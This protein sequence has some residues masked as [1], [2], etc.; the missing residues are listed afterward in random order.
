MKSK[1]QKILEYIKSLP[2]GNKI[3]VRQVAKDLKV[4][5]GTAY[6]AIKES[7][8]RGFV[9]SIERVGTV[10]IQKKERD[11]I[12]K[13]SY[14]EIVNIV[15]GQ[16]IA[17]RG[18]IH[19]IVQDFAIGAMDEEQVSQHIR[20]GTLLI[21]GNR[22]NI[23]S[24]ALEKDCAI[25]VAG[26][27]VPSEDIRKIADKKN[28]PLIVTPHDS[29]SVAHLINRVTNDQ[30]IKR[31]IVTVESIY[32]PKES[33]YTINIMS[34][35]QDWY[36]LQLEVGHTRFPV[37]NEYGKL[38]GIV[39]ARDVFSKHKDISIRD[40]MERKVTTA[41]LNDPVSSVGN[42]MLSEG[43]EL[44]PVID[45]KNTLLGIVTRKIVINSMLTNN[46]YQENQN[47]DTFDEII[48]KG[49]VPRADGLQIKVIPQ[50]LDQF[51]TFSRSALLSI[52]DESIHIT[53]YNY[54]RSEVLMQNVN[55]YFLKTVPLDRIIT[56][57]T[58]IMDIGRKSAKFDVE[59]YD[60]NDLVAKALVTCQVF[61]RN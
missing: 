57:K 45:I 43:F 34:T 58:I 60:K 20:K 15:G 56:T 44:M 52:I 30:I 16:L 40:V 12:E 23:I 53:S 2:I 41:Q 10:R 24:M 27:Y 33:I 17:G 55:L 8:N 42:T 9:S 59:V 32:I 1:H 5:E 26:G 29:F 4:S 61:Q 22:P 11:N 35:V 36:D 50:M 51:G 7:E 54:N 31:D 46:R 21:V 13:L 28:L 47:S 39:T 37:V 3:S 14:S 19:E 48:R 38:V 6:R 18:G 49:I 25:L